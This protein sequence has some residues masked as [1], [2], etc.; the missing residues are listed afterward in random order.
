MELVKKNINEIKPYENNP[1][2]NDAAVDA[3]A[4]SIRQCEYI[5]PIVIDENCVILAGHT[6]LKALQKLGYTECECIVKYGLTE[7]QKR[8]YRVLDNKTNEFA[9]WDYDLLAEE[10]EDLDFEGFDFGFDD[11]ERDIGYGEDFTLPEGDRET[12]CVMKFS[13][14]QEQKETIESAIA[15]MKES[16]EYRQYKGDN[17]NSNGNALYLLVLRGW[18]R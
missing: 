6:R 17:E 15:D 10:L 3:V 7:E 2:I 13:L 9:F 16:D 12:G 4:E 18:N 11:I 8:K 14:S 1:R 5:A